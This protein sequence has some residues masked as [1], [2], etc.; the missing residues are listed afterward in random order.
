MRL[1]ARMAGVFLS[2]LILSQIFFLRGDIQ[3]FDLCPRP[4]GLSQKFQAGFDGWVGLEAADIDSIAQLA[5]AQALN[6]AG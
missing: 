2:L 6:Q 4:G 5:P 3:F 1:A